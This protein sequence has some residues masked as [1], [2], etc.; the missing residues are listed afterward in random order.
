M[1]CKGEKKWVGSIPGK[2]DGR[3]ATYLL[4]CGGKTVLK[5]SGGARWILK[6]FKPLLK[7]TKLLCGL[8]HRFYINNVASFCIILSATSSDCSGSMTEMKLLLLTDSQILWLSESISEGS[9]A[10]K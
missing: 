2:C 10:I 9:L 3:D 4:L 7:P 6:A 1:C 5:Q 8:P